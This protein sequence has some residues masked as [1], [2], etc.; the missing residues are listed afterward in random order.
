MRKITK[1]IWHCSATREGQDVSTEAIR[2]M[3]KTERGWSD[4]GYH[5]V[6]ELDGVA[7]TGRD[8]ERPGAHTQGH[9][10]ESIGICYVGGVERDGKTPKDTRTPEQRAELYR[11]TEELLERFPV[12]TVHGHR[13]FAAKACPSFDVQKDWAAHVAS[14]G[15]VQLS[16]DI[17]P[18]LKPEDMR[19]EDYEPTDIDAGDLEL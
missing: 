15:G 9:N 19:D 4:I 6:I 5:F 16:P 3:H 8:L 17:T 13:E 11:L 12:A 14:R 7:H 18:G 10:E 2:R 1:I